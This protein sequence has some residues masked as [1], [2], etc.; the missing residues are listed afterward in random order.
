[1]ASGAADGEVRLWDLAR[2]RCTKIF[3]GHEGRFVRGIVYNPNGQQILSVGDDKHICTWNASDEIE[4][5]EPV[6]VK[7]A[8]EIINSKAMLTG[9][10]YH[11]HEE[12]FATCGDIT[13]LWDASTNYPIKEFQ[14]GVD[15]VHTIKFNQVCSFFLFELFMK[16]LVFITNESSLY[17]VHIYKIQCLKFISGG[18]SYSGSMCQ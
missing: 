17:L 13:Q 8:T 4:E 12:K 11:R 10:S 3:R 2:K 9:I 1:M 14:W 6:V 7:E 15:T 16:Y 5:G 18:T